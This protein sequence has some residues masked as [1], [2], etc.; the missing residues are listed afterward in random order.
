MLT[1]EDLQAIED[2]MDR[3]LDEKLEVKLEEKLEEKL[4]VKLEEKLD[5][6]LDE[7]LDEKLDIKLEEKF[8]PMVRDEINAALQ[9]FKTDMVENEIVPRIDESKLEMSEMMDRKLLPLQ[10]EIS[11]IRVDLLENNV[12]PRLNTIENCY[13][14]TYNRYAANADKTEAMC[15]DISV[16]KTVVR[17][18]SEQLRN[19]SGGR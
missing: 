6:K 3:K 12:I 4:E 7:K 5:R 1:K 2:I 11:M 14:S 13:L 18:H 15:E 17:N 16:L 8:R 19:L 9:A 10:K